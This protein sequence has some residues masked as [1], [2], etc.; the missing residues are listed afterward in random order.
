MDDAGPPKSGR[1]TDSTKTTI[2]VLIAL[3]VV[4]IAAG[5]G[6]A[7][8][9]DA[10]DTV[11]QAK[12]SVAAGTTTTVATV[13]GVTTTTVAPADLNPEQSRIVDEIKAQVSTIRGLA[14]KGTLPI[15]VVSK[16]ELA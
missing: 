8:V 3:V 15:K 5:I 13:P 12:S 2:G 11:H 16:E 1:F 14:W 6:I 9:R 10:K 7:A 4:L